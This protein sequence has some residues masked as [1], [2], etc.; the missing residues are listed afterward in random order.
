MK[1]QHSLYVLYNNAIDAYE[2]LPNHERKLRVQ[3]PLQG[4][5][6]LGLESL[7]YA[8]PVFHEMSPWIWMVQKKNTIKVTWLLITCVKTKHKEATVS[9]LKF[10]SWKFSNG[11]I[12]GMYSTDHLGHRPTKCISLIFTRKKKKGYDLL[13]CVIVIFTSG[14][15][16][17]RSMWCAAA[18][19]IQ[20]RC[21]YKTSTVDRI[22]SFGWKVYGIPV[23][24]G[25]LQ[26]LS[27]A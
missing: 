27:K 26:N 20:T 10:L 16:L 1:R 14:Y 12:D 24:F 13:F 15:I 18:T 9:F 7:T 23:T 19:T 8:T 6:I 2:L 17:R 3:F 4:T 11:T 22:W 5:E 21:N 25:E